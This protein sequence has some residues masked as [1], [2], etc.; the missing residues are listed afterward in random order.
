MDVYCFP[1][2]E[3][4]SSLNSNGCHWILERLCHRN[5]FPDS[6]P[7]HGS[8]CQNIFVLSVLKLTFHVPLCIKYYSF[9]SSK[10]IFI[11][12]FITRVSPVSGFLIKS[13]LT[14]EKSKFRSFLQLLSWYPVSLQCQSPVFERHAFS[15]TIISLSS[16]SLPQG[17]CSVISVNISNVFNYSVLLLGLRINKRILKQAAFNSRTN[18]YVSFQLGIG[19]F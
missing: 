15:L 11:Y 10:L 17:I 14:G 19:S 3:C 12:F 6:F 4:T 2:R 13:P 8:T 7:R 18:S 16:Y 1:E 5:V 9:R